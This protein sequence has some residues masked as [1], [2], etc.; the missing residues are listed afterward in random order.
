MNCEINYDTQRVNKV[1][2]DGTVQ[3]IEDESEYIETQAVFTTDSSILTNEMV[4]D[5][6]N[7]KS[8]NIRIL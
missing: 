4:S 8:N 5:V 1:D 6:I 7:A 3:N 2:N